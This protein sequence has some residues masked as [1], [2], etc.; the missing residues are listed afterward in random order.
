MGGTVKKEE[1]DR[2]FLHDLKMLTSG[3]SDLSYN[4]VVNQI[5]PISVWCD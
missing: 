2:K 5:Q 1:R 4:D 3:Y